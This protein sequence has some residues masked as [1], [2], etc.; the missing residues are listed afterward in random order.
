VP[1]LFNPHLGLEGFPCDRPIV[2]VWR[3]HWHGPATDMTLYFTGGAMVMARD[4][5]IGQEGFEQ[6]MSFRLPADTDV[7]V[8][9]TA[10]V[11]SAPVAVLREVFPGGLRAP[12]WELFTPLPVPSAP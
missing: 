10:P 6:T 2:Y 7:T 9:L 8:V 1:F 3:A 12:A 5:K 11:G 4:L